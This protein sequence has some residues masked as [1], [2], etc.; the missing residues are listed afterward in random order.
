MRYQ[1]QLDVAQKKPGNNFNQCTMDEWIGSG[2]G[3][4]VLPLSMNFSD[5]LLSKLIPTKAAINV[6][7]EKLKEH[8]GDTPSEELMSLQVLKSAIE[9]DLISF[10][11]ALKVFPG[12][13]NNYYPG[14]GG[15]TPLVLA[16]CFSQT[17]IVESLLS[18]HSADPD[19]HDTIVNYTP[20]MWA[21]YLDDLDTAKLL[22]DYQADPYLSP[23]DDDKSAVSLVIPEKVQMYEFFQLHNLIKTGHGGDD[24]YKGF[25][26]E[27]DPLADSLEAKLKLQT[28]S[29]GMEEE[30]E[31]M[32][33][34]E[35]DENFLANDTQ[36]IQIL[37]F[38]YDKLLPEQYIKFTDSDIPSLLDYTFG[39]R[40]SKP[41]F[42]HDTKLPAAIMF[43]LLRYSCLKV[44]STELTTFLFDCFIARLRSVTNTKS[45]AFNLATLDTNGGSSQQAGDIV[46]LSYWLS[47][48]Q[49]LHF[50]LSRG[51]IYEH[52]PEFQTE[53]TTLLQSLVAT[54]SFSINA[55]LN[56]LVDD[57]MIN[58]TNLVDVS[59]V[60][61]AKDWNFFKNKKS[62]HPNTYDDI[63]A[64][65]Y[66]PS[67]NELMKP[68]PIR[69]LQ[70]FGALD[71]VLNVHRL[72]DLIKAQTY[73][74]VFYYVNAVI[75]N[76]IIGQSKYCTRAKAIQIRLN[77]STIED[78]LR[79][80]NFKVARAENPHE[81]SL[82]NIGKY[83]LQA[84]IELLQFL[85]C[86]SLL[87]DEESLINT[88]N[89]FEFLNYAQMFKVMNK[90]Y[91]YEVDE[92]RIPKKHTQLLKNL[93]N[94]QGA[95]QLES[96]PFTYIALTGF[97][98]KDTDIFINPNHIFEVEYPGLIAL[99]E[100]YGVG[101]G[102]VHKLR[103]KKY[104]PSLPIVILDDI[105]EILTENRESNFNDT[106]D[107]ETANNQDDEDDA[108]QDEE[109]LLSA[110]SF[111]RRPSFK[112]DE[113]F[114]T[115]QMPNTLAHKHWGESEFEEN[116][117]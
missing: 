39:L 7:Y 96:I 20:L 1:N 95:R 22:L 6:A 41:Q 34:S 67:Q 90:M 33:Y 45:G 117:W 43:Q 37:E 74:Q 77:I 42:Q 93:Y 110:P 109:E 57:C 48:L 30:P 75:F 71:Y 53:M 89:Q 91:K 29:A 115:V 92:P 78:W 14:P 98:S 47:M 113:L 10:E 55:R 26:V 83:R 46:L 65:L 62:K 80:H 73:T 72:N 28:I 12:L 84:T 51:K 100:T 25:G 58:F 106:Y 38:D 105:D 50:Y 40:V 49:F 86:V 3:S 11:A 31:E 19:L 111:E 23:L 94:E 54:I 116:P 69:Y 9:G 66:P 13:V 15:V 112:G 5:S 101:L 88:I 61:Y 2:F 17:D 114:K 99:T 52:H 97:L 44:N 4:V 82:F 56:A 21:V 79:S 36:L 68:S 104:Q 87:P 102:G 32:V 59:N 70:V 8:S 60:L 18:N 81:K 64:M 27:D 16:V 24:F 35:D 63:M 76:R 103:S 85:Q 107:Y 108:K